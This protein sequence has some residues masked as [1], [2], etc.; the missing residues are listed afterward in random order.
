MDYDSV[1]DLIISFKDDMKL[2][3]IEPE[4]KDKI[5]KK[6]VADLGEFYVLKELCYR[7]KEVHPKGGQGG[8]DI[9]VGEYK[10]RIEVKTSTLKND[11]LYDKQMKLWGWTVS[12]INQKKE[13]KFDILIGVALDDTWKNPKY[14]VFTYDEA[15]VKNTNIE[16]KRFKNIQKK[17][18]IFQN[19][20]DL[21]LAQ[22]I[23]Q[24]E[25]SN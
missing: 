17:I 9:S 23:S 15:Y 25:I 8:Y 16:L 14:Y 4:K 21:K 7:F 19:E 22:S 1:I 3:D 24:N 10:T 2:L 6:L 18:H 13:Y 12:R 11:G 20:K 5:P